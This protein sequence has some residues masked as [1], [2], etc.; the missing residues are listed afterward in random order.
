MDNTRARIL[1]LGAAGRDFHNFNTVFRNNPDFQVVAFTA[2]QIPRI[3]GRVYPPELAGDG[4]PD[5]I[6]ILPEDQLE[7]IIEEQ[8]VDSVVF[9]YSDV[10]HEH[11][12]HLACRASARGADFWLVS[13]YS[14]MLKAT[15]PVVS[16]CAVRTGCGKSQTARKAARLLRDRGLRVGV[17][18]HPM[19]YGDLALQRAQRF[20]SLDDL[21]THQCTIEEREEYEQYIELGI[22]LFAGVDYRDVLT[23]A[24]KESDII[25]WDG[26]N[27]DTPFIFPD[28]NIVV[29]DP[30]RPGHELSYFPG[31]VN[32]RAAD[33]VVLNKVDS[34]RAEDI[35]T[36]LANVHNAVPGAVV[37]QAAS[38]IVVDDPD[39]VAGKRVLVVE[40][41]P[42]LT[43]GGMA[44]GAGL[45]AAKQFG[46]AEIIDPREFAVGSIKASY[47]LYPHIGNIVPALG[48]FDE[49]LAALQETIN[50]A[51]CDA[52]IIGTPVDLTK[53]MDIKHKAVRTT[54]S[55][56]ELPGQPTLEEVL[57]KGLNL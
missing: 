20:G 52:V 18:R 37:I 31:E 17:I 9:S 14:T 5:G 42:T 4:Y 56:Q 46:A 15:R 29:T 11:V 38:K 23:M 27:N 41:G 45:V 34:A 7:E 32:L 44:F 50:A 12:M 16:V 25:I 53:F 43:H 21:T 35:E 57:A 10:S 28:L 49:Q 33:V 54:Y 51:D 8:Q 6:P 2:A 48:Y 40:D 3:A 19:P 1:I 30:L 39:A 24:E 47:E 55:L 22:T 36:V 13:A 26:G